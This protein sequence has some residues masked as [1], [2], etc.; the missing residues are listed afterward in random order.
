MALSTKY[1][2]KS[3]LSL[4]IK[5]MQMDFPEPST[6]PVDEYFYNASFPRYS[7]PQIWNEMF[8]STEH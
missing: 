8:W 5:V 3:K 6:F 1:L 7:F 2:T 4:K